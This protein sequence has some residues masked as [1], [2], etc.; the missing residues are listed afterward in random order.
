MILFIAATR[1]ALGDLPGEPLGLGAVAAAARTAALIA[2]E[3]PDEVVLLGT[4]GSYPGG[5]PVGSAVVAGR[6][7]LSPG[8]ATMGLGYVPKAPEPLACAPQLTGRLTAPVVD[9]LTVHAITTDP[10]LAERLSDGGW[11]VEHLEAYGAALA[12]AQAGVPFAAVLGVASEVGPE[13]HTHWLLHRQDAQA[14]ARAA[15]APLLAEAPARP[16]RIQ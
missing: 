14:A 8:V 16:A 4:C 11:S 10:V 7:G 3:D 6:V 15:L 12:C 1:E 5:P 13:A 2:R 9:V